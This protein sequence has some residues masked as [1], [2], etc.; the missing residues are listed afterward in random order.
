[1]LFL[2]YLDDLDQER[3]MLAEL[4]GKRTLQHIIADKYPADQGDISGVSALLHT[5]KV[6]R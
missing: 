3:S 2:K 6:D 4:E 1:M 5:D